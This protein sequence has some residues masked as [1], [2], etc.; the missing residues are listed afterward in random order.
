MR[1]KFALAALALLVT[2]QAAAEWSLAT[3][4]DAAS[5]APVTVLSRGANETIGDEYGSKQ[6]RP[7]LEFRCAAG[8]DSLGVRIDW[9]RFISSF[10]TEV[11]FAADDSDALA[12]KFGVDRSNEITIAKSGDDAEALA[13]YLAGRESLAVTVTPYSSVPETVSFDLED[14]DEGLAQLRAACGG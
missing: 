7:R 2:A 12:L 14:F 5:Y 13:A 1:E 3:A 10:N 8:S 11:T 6:V 9:Q 4:T